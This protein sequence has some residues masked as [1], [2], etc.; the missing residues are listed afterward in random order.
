[1][2]A[3]VTRRTDALDVFAT[4]G[5]PFNEQYGRAGHPTLCYLAQDELFQP[6]LP[7][8]PIQAVDSK[9]HRNLQA[10]GYP[11]LPHTAQGLRAGT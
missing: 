3:P 11:R 6:I 10:S 9:H 5:H 2:P 1:M 7:G 4:P 8:R